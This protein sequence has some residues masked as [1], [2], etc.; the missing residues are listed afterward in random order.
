MQPLSNFGTAFRTELYLAVRFRNPPASQHGFLAQPDRR[1]AWKDHMR[2]RVE[3]VKAKQRILIVRSAKL[4][5]ESK[6]M[7]AYTRQI[8]LDSQIKRKSTSCN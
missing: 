4:I 1:T 6:A 3:G 2:Q 8:I 7:I 5:K